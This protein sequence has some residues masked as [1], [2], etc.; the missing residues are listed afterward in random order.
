MV[1]GL[2]PVTGPPQW[3]TDGFTLPTSAGSIR[4]RAKSLEAHA[5][6]SVSPAACMAIQELYASTPVLDAPSTAMGVP[7]S[8][9]AVVHPT[10]SVGPPMLVQCAAWPM[11]TF[12]A[13]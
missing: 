8:K 1:P 9:E 13:S 11:Y 2:V 10:V 7:R 5:L 12:W 4:T 6:G 3:G